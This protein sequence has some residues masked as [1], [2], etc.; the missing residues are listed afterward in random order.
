MLKAACH[1]CAEAREFID[2]IL[3]VAL[4][5]GTNGVEVPRLAFD[6]LWHLTRGESYV[7]ALMLASYDGRC[8]D[9]DANPRIEISRE[10]GAKVVVVPHDEGNRLCYPSNITVHKDRD[11]P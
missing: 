1:P 8:T 3:A 10:D 4:T 2:E 9:Y 11:T 7:A 5:N 6:V